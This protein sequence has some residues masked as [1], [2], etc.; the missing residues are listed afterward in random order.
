MAFRRSRVR[1]ASA[2]PIKS[3]TY[4]DLRFGM[5]GNCPTSVRVL[6]C[7][8]VL[9]ARNPRDLRLGGLLGQV[10]VKACR[11]LEQVGLR[12]DVI[13][14]KDAAGLVPGQLHRDPL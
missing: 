2:P 14:V 7:R 3:S 1:S 4:V 13:A 10:L 11:R 8:R 12:N 9:A 6:G 5:A